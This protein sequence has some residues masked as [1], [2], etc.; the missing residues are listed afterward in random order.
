MLVLLAGF[1]LFILV[2]WVSDE[3]GPR[4]LATMEESMVDMA[5]VLASH[6]ETQAGE[7][8]LDVH[9]LRAAFEKANRKEFS[10]KIYELDKKRLN[11]RVYV[12][13]ARGIVIFDSDG[14]KDEGRD[15]SR[16]NDVL[17]TLRG[18]YG[19]RTVPSFSADPDGAVLYVASPVKAGGEIV[20]VLTVCKPA[21]S[22]SLFL[23]TARGQVAAAGFLAALAVVLLGFALS[24]W[25]TRPIDRLTRYALAVRDD[26]RAAAPEL[27]ANEIGELGAAFVEMKDELE[28]KQYVENYIQTLTH[29]M[30]S[31]LSAIRG[32]AELLHED[33]PPEQRNRFLEN[34]RAESERIRDF[35]DRLLQLSV[36][37]KRTELE[38]VEEIDLE[39]MIHEIAESMEP[40]LDAKNVSISIEAKTSATVRGERFLLRQAI[41]NLLQNAADFSPE[42]GGI[43]V[44][45][46]R[47]EDRVT[48]EIRDEGP[49]VPDYARGKV[50][51]RFYSLSRPSDGKKSTGL[52]LAFVREAALLHGGEATL[53]NAPD[54]GALA[55]LTLPRNLS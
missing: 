31:P 29:E 50:F 42:G 36:L 13:D 8:D 41:A 5:A 46:E 10:A 16:W 52:G 44:V 40:S 9:G 14:G 38:D 18:E 1:G 7:R 47:R 3:L 53:E 12:T 17:L 21:K 37:E 15:Y 51:D 26:R 2:H 43:N 28:G 30:K 22:V 33:M 48:V 23:A 35:I 54:G 27:G 4:Y 6:L 45:A 24:F 11:M 19:A 39:R 20:G 49:G 25:I 34:I 55:I 32:A